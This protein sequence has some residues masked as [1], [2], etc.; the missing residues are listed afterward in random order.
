MSETII[1]P[2]T[3]SEH[4]Y[5]IVARFSKALLE[6]L[7]LVQEQLRNVLG[8][9]IWLTPRNALHSTLMEIICDREYE[10]LSRERHFLNWFK[11]YDQKASEIIA[12]IKPFDIRFTDLEISQRAIIVKASN[13]KKFNITRASLLSNI[14]LPRGTKQPPDITHCTL[15]RFNEVLNVESVIGQTKTIAVDFTERVNN[16]KLLKDLGPPSFDPKTIQTY[17]LHSGS[18][19]A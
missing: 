19:A 6:Q 17:Q 11:Q 1:T 10:D 13:S 7:A 4:E 2:Q 14:D 15:A 9:T 16:F 8:D 3:P 5:A 18:D 12:S